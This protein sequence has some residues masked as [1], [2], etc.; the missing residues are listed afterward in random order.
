ML[1]FKIVIAIGMTEKQNKMI[2]RK[3]IWVRTEGE[4]YRTTKIY[5]KISLT[6]ILYYTDAH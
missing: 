3:E 2:K 4:W 5:S 6:N 1:N